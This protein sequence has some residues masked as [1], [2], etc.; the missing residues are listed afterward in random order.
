M[1]GSCPKGERVYGST[2]FDGAVMYEG[3]RPGRYHLEL[4]A[5]Q[6]KRLGMRLTHPVEIEVG[7]QGRAITKNA[8][9]EFERKT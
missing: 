4:D 8:E 3:V 1:S 7:A 9:I 6:A 5:D 2:E